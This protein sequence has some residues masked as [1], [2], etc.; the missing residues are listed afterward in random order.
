MRRYDMP[1]ARRVEF[2]PY[3]PKMILNKG[4]WADHWFWT[5]YT[6]YPY[7]GCMH[8][9]EFCYCLARVQVTINLHQAD[10]S[11][12]LGVWVI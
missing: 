9:C 3:R 6:A 12:I 11:P 1:M 8:G 4:K 5:R 10:P 7:K 2:V